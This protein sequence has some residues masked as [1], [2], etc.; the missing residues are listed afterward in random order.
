MGDGQG[1]RG[2]L[3]WELWR[4]GSSTN[5]LQALGE[6]LKELRLIDSNIAHHLLKEK[7][8]LGGNDLLVDRGELSLEALFFFMEGCSSLHVME[9][10]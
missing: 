9:G 8:A 4:V 7:Q 10:P 5:Q 6:V 2:I 1:K 3:G